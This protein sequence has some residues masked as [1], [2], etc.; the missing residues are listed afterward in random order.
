[1]EI[2]RGLSNFKIRFLNGGQKLEEF[3]VP[4]WVD[5]V[6]LPPVKPDAEMKYIQSVDATQSLDDLKVSRREALLE[7]Y[8]RF[9]PDV[10]VL[11][12]FPFGRRQFVFELLPLL[13]RTR[14]RGQ[15]T[16][17]V[18]SVR[19]ILVTQPAHIHHEEWVCELLNR[20]FDVVLVHSDPGFQTLQETFSRVNDI[21][22]EIRYTGY[23]VQGANGHDPARNGAS[24]SAR[25]AAQPT[26]VVSVGGG[27][28][29]NELLTA[30]AKASA[31]LEESRP[32]RM[33]M[34]AGPFLPEPQFA[35]L[36][37]LVGGRPNVKLRRYTQH[38]LS[39]LKH[40]DLSVSM[41]GYNTC[42]NVLT[43]GC[44]ALVLPFASPG[45]EE[46]TIRANKLERLGLVNVI[47]PDELAPE[48]LAE[49]MRMALEMEPPPHRLDTRGVEQSG[50]LITALV[51]GQLPSA[52]RHRSPAYDT[53]RE[54]L[55]PSVTELRS[56][57]ERCEREG[58]TVDVF[59]RDDDV[60]QEES[61]LRRLLDVALVRSVPLN[62]EVIPGVLPDSNG[63]LLQ[64]YKHYFPT[65]LELNQHGWQH[66]NHERIGKK[67]EFGLNRS[68]EQQLEDIS[69]GKQTLE[70]AFSDRFHAVFTPPWNRCT[71]DTMLALDRLGF[72]VL[73]RS[74]NGHAEATGHGFREIPITLDLFRWK[75]GA[76][77][78]SRQEIV[79]DLVR[80]LDDGG[81]IG[82]ML[83][84][85]VMG[86]EAF[87][88]LEGLLDELIGH[89]V[90][91]FHTFRS[92]L[93]SSNT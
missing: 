17:V 34:F 59:L 81:T 90:V 67:S 87:A 68:F 77:L 19:D 2:T 40:A 64:E 12:L 42:M 80:Q 24:V 33:L 39:C 7:E 72:R 55:G 35:D 1:M 65:L 83:H 15:S 48:A 32:H 13:A 4:P 41:A 47:R 14:Q 6:N 3:S 44:R 91:R 92:L 73:S 71:D 51:D 45:N 86:A 21:H 26:I 69:R 74:R 84:H 25:R 89:P 27:R 54:A 23:V 82:L 53:G 29:G 11:E 46:Q 31:I 79:T 70:Q 5:L 50:R 78:R 22:T 57:L 76:A 52:P 66:R 43:T 38:F 75:D 60:E 37:R 8:E 61:S 56:R 49:K 63:E 18:C 93:V 85:K 36:S 28:V 10:L 16:K 58:R 88:F 20:Y 9:Q 30:V 62:L